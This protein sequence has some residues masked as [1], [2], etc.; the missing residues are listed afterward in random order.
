MKLRRPREIEVQVQIEELVLHGFAPSDRYVIG[1]AVERELVRLLS[2]KGVPRSLRSENA[3][4]EIKAP[5]F[6]AALGAKQ[7]AIGQ[8]IAQAVYD[9]FS[10]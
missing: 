3:R 10:Q 7:P 8:Q 5:S 2:E 1:E 4:D 6:N 9:G